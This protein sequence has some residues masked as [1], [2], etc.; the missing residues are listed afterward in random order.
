[1]SIEH[2]MIVYDTCHALL[3]L[4]GATRDEARTT[5]ATC[6]S[7]FDQRVTTWQIEA[8]T[9]DLPEATAALFVDATIGKCAQFAVAL[10][11]KW[12]DDDADQ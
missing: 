11:Q 6:I 7:D 9:A 4:A 10:H 3:V 5:A 8:A 2:E 12:E 1:M